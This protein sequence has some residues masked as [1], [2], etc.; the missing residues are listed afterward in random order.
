MK[1]KI[2]TIS[3]IFIL[4]S[5]IFIN[6]NVFASSYD[7]NDYKNYISDNNW[8]IVYSDTTTEFYLLIPEGRWL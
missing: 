6:N 2:L 5:F 3:I 1:N 8:A 7:L 4:L